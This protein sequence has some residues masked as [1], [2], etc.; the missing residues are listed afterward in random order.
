MRIPIARMFVI[1]FN[2]FK[3]KGQKFVV[4]L[5]DSFTH[6]AHLSDVINHDFRYHLRCSLNKTAETNK[7]HTI[8]VSITSF[9][10]NYR[11]AINRLLIIFHFVFNDLSIEMV[12]QRSIEWKQRTH[13]CKQMDSS[14]RSNLHIHGHTMFLFVFVYQ[15]LSPSVTLIFSPVHTIPVHRKLFLMSV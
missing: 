15:I 9:G 5:L 4:T 1:L 6:T 13:N 12:H 14:N 2:M 11:L 10:N 8:H 7:Q 3:W